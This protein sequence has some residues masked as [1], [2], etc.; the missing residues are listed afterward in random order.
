MKASGFLLSFL[1]IF[2]LACTNKPQQNMKDEIK[3]ELNK[4][5]ALLR[6][7]DYNFAMAQT[8]E[9][10]Y[11]KGTGKAIPPFL[12]SNEET[13]TK[14]IFFKE[15]E[16][17]TNLAGFYAL[18][19]GLGWICSQTNETPVEVLKKINNHTLDS[20]F[21]ILL[22][23]FA[24]ATWKAGQ[25]FRAMERIT[26]PTFTCFNFLPDD[27][28]IKDEKQIYYASSQMLESMHDVSASSLE[29][30]MLKIRSLI[31]DENFAII[32]AD[33]LY[34]LPSVNSNKQVSSLHLDDTTTIT[35]SIKEEKIAINVAGFYA[36]ECGLNYFAANKKLP[37]QVLQSILDN[38]ISA[39][40]KILLQRF[41]NATWKAG[42][43]FRGLNRIERENFVPFY[44]LSDEEKEKDW[45][46][47]KAAAEKL[48]KDIK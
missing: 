18:E 11:Y 23:R 37:S 1:P 3:H 44:F 25:P 19:C 2:T 24:N 16:I 39:D 46:Q 47:I 21:L 22:N 4:I 26:R 20:A 38:S 6:S 29:M 33:N 48:L 41:A 10:A 15:E 7:A 17:A 42:Q 31:Q 5:D 32:M 9:A 36:L 40:D 14:K 43:P 13:A 30:Q 12:S 8:L 34:A 45:V 35:R 27:E 28:L